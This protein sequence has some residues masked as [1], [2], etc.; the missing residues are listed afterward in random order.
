MKHIICG[1]NRP[2]S[3]SKL[4]STFVQKI[5]S[6]LN[7]VVEI[8]DLADLELCQ[9]EPD[10]IGGKKPLPPKLQKAVQDV[11][12][13]DGL[14]IVCPEYNGGMPGVLKTFIDFWKFPDSFESRPVCYIGVAS[15][16]WGGLHPIDHLTQ[17]FGYR[18]S[19][20][21]PL[22]VYFKEVHKILKNGQI[23]DPFY[24]KMLQNQANG[25]LKF[26]QALK[27]AGLD[28]NSIPR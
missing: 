7:E 5:Y 21:F 6:D 17:V 11:T 10:H 26:C 25:F 18:N 28:A 13:S 2:G 12:Q 4:I 20:Q 1:T 15:G 14:I 19:Y 3:N 8:I 22:K 24:L 16:Q 23:E 27:S 9:L